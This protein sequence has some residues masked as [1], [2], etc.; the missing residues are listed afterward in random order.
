MR[1]VGVRKV[2]RY[3]ISHAILP[4]AHEYF[5]HPAIGVG[6]DIGSAAKELHKTTVRRHIKQLRGSIPGSSTSRVDTDNAGRASFEVVDEDV[7]LPVRIGSDQ[8]RGGAFKDNVAAV[9]RKPRL[10]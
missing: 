10:L 2:G 5:S 8:V 7:A 9:L 6:K 1:G 4:V 3:P